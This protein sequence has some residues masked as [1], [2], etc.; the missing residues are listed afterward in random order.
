L[1]RGRALGGAPPPTHMPC[2]CGSWLR[3][4]VGQLGGITAVADSHT[5]RD[6][7]MALLVLFLGRRRQLCAVPGPARKVFAVGS[8]ACTRPHE[9]ARLHTPPASLVF[10]TLSL[11]LRSQTFRSPSIHHRSRP[12]SEFT[13]CAP[14]TSLLL[15][16]SFRCAV[17]GRTPTRRSPPF[18]FS[19]MFLLSTLVAV[20]FPD[21][22]CPRQRWSGTTTPTAPSDPSRP[23]P[24]RWLCALP[25]V[26]FWPLFQPSEQ[27][28]TMDSRVARA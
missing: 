17:D 26:N 16:S 4:I 15:L 11:V 21:Q 28:R 2:V 27:P 12:G 14:V 10:F 22:I 18:P 9:Y 25:P 5:P 1:P 3:V 20:F 7:S 24:F 19:Y 13:L 8:W 23:P 6:S